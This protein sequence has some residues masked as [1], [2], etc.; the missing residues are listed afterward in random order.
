MN[1]TVFRSR[2]R[3]TEKAHWRFCDRNVLVEKIWVEEGW[4]PSG[5]GGYV[6]TEREEDKNWMYMKKE[7]CY[8]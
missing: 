7:C 4:A 2:S 8:R 3:Q 5:T 6:S 1:E